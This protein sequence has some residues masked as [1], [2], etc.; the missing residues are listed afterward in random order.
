MSESAIS[1][2]RKRQNLAMVLSVPWPDS[3]PIITFQVNRFSQA[4]LTA[5]GHSAEK[6]LRDRGLR[7]SD[8][9]WADEY[10]FAFAMAL[11]EHVKRH[12]KGWEH[13]APEGEERLVYNQGNLEGIFREMSALDKMLLGVSYMGAMNPEKNESAPA[14]TDGAS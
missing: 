12:V 5:A 7:S 11:A 1:R 8:S 6:I 4:E 3:E 9:E 10:R 14:N 2:F 13:H